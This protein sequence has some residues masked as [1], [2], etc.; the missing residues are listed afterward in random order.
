MYTIRNNVFETNSSAC[1]C[2]TVIPVDE[3]KKMYHNQYGY[4]IHIPDTGQYNT[5]DKY[6]LLTLSEAFE[7]YNKQLAVYEN[8]ENNKN[9]PVEHYNDEHEFINAVKNGTISVSEEFGKFLTY[10]QVM[11]C[12][13]PSTDGKLD[14]FWWNFE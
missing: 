6:E 2:L 1:H 3:L 14:V 13:E 7:L 12:I 9:W 8:N 4:L 5:D 10:A 11:S